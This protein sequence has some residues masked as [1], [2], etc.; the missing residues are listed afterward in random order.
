MFTIKVLIL[1]M[2][3]GFFNGGGIQVTE[4]KNHDIDAEYTTQYHITYV[5]EVAD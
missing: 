5:Q 3:I 1:T 2:Y 4:I